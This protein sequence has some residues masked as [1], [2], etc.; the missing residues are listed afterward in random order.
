MEIFLIKALQLIFSLSIIVI[1]HEFGHFIFARLFKIRVEKFYLFFNPWF[2]LLKF[3]P[4]N[5][6]TE[7]GIGWLPLGGYVKIAGMMDESFDEEQLKQP[8]KSW[9]FRS[10]PAWQRLLV[11]SGGVIFNFI[12]AFV[13]YSIMVFHWGETSVDTSKLPKGMT[14]STVAKNAGFQD[15]DIIE[16]V[17]GKTFYLSGGIRSIND[18][19]SFLEAKNVVVN[20]KGEKINITIPPH[21]SN[22]ITDKQQ[23]PIFQ[24]IVPTKI[25]YIQ[26]NSI[27][28]NNGLKVGDVIYSINHVVTSNFDELSQE[29]R[30]YPNQTIPISYIRNN[31]TITK[32]I[33]LAELPVLGISSSLNDAVSNR[34]FSLFKSFSEGGRIAV[35]TLSAYAWQMKFVF[36]KEGVSNLG[37]FGSLGNLFPAKWNWN[38]FWSLTAFL[39]VAIGFFNILPIPMLDG[40]HIM[41]LLYEVVTRRKP[42]DEFMK[43][44]Q[45]FG[46]I[47]LIAVMIFANGN[48]VMKLFSK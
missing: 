25:A 32:D 8:Q 39:S 30:K 1:V 38:A 4:K 28:E 31:D 20:R 41:F 2:S 6:H 43:N 17:D 23:E 45:L 18:I 10:K 9:E 47:L 16:T 29:L 12:L 13:I 35:E 5:S 24:V 33:T 42:S 11:M 36:S 37:G 48:D 27:A 34:Q 26:P 40:G 46:F 3:K 14:F 19:M 21:F 44:M 22:S 7:Y 15:G